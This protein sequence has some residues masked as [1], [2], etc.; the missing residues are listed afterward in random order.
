MKRNNLILGFVILALLLVG[1]GFAGLTG[2][3]TIDGKVKTTEAAMDV[4][5]V[6]FSADDGYT[7]EEGATPHKA[8]I[9][10][11]S[12]KEKNDSKTI[13]FKVKNTS[14]DYKA[15]LTAHT[16]QISGANGYFSIVVQDGPIE[17]LPGDFATFTV[18]ITLLKASTEV[19]TG[20]IAVTY[21]WEVIPQ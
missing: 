17:V 7:P 6:D 20:T 21:S 11:F 4:I 3:L 19:Q 2:T 16:Q 13:T 5:F 10:E 9:D 8:T 15:R 12:L 18:T 14:K 1:I